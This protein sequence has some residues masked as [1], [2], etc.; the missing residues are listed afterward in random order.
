LR[1]PGTRRAAAQD[2]AVRIKVSNGRAQ[3][4]DGPFAEAKEMVGAS[5]DRR[6]FPHRLR[7]LHAAKSLQLG[8]PH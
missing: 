6:R 2:N 3:L 8:A 5:C 4:I 7:D 1:N